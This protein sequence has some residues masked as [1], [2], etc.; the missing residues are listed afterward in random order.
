MDKTA[1]CITEVYLER[2]RDLKQDG[3]YVNELNITKE[4]VSGS[5]T[6]MVAKGEC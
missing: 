6:N 4:A 2:Y 5:S 3:H 1:F